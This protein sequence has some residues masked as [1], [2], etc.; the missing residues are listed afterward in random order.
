MKPK[1]FKNIT[2]LNEMLAYY[3]Y[4]KCISQ[5]ARKYK[6]DRSS[7]LYQIAKAKIKDSTYHLRNSDNY[8]VKEKRC[9]V[10]EMLLSSPNHKKCY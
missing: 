7:I 5:T 4:C 3:Q 9:S 1:V 6:C 2:K 8:K 10:C